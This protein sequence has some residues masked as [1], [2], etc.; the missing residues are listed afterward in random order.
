MNQNDD[1]DTQPVKAYGARCQSN[2]KSSH[3]YRGPTGDKSA[4]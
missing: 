2:L 1:N 3:F 4:R